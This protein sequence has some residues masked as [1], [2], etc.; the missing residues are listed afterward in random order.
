MPCCTKKF[1][2]HVRW[3]I[4]KTF[5]YQLKTWVTIF[6]KVSIHICHFCSIDKN[7]FYAVQHNGFRN[8]V[9]SNA[10]KTIDVFKVFCSEVWFH[11]RRFFFLMSCP[12]PLRR[13][14]QFHWVNVKVTRLSKLTSSETTS[15]RV[16]AS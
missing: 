9:W 4:H 12:P 3:I 6:R 16:Y 2:I 13:M 11:T 5:P 10:F 7:I 8:L 14:I 15:P 1:S